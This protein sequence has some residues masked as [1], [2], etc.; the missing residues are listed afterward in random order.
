MATGSLICGWAPLGDPGGG[1][2]GSRRPWRGWVWRGA[3]PL[4]L[5]SKKERVVKTPTDL[6]GGCV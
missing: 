4:P 1:S 6:V 5:G 2:G 3:V